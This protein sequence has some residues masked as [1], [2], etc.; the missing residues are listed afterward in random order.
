[1]DRLAELNSL[2]VV[3]DKALRSR[4]AIDRLMGEEYD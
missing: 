2:C 4:N 3:I 1:V